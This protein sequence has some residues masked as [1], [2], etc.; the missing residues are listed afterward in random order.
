MSDIRENI[1][2]LREEAIE[3]CQDKLEEAMLFNG[4]PN[5]SRIYVNQCWI[6]QALNIILEDMRE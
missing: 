2:K 5:L 3:L 1:K 6:M 4:E